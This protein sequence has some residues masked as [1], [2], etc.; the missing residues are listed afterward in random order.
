MEHL[1]PLIDCLIESCESD[2]SINLVLQEKNETLREVST[3][4]QDPTTSLNGKASWNI[5]Y[6][7]PRPELLAQIPLGEKHFRVA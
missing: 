4:A 3:L 2:T 1:A 6:L 5:G 7:T